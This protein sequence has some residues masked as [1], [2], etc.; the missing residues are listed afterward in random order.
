MKPETLARWKHTRSRGITR[1]ILVT[2]VLSWG[3]PM[4]AVMTFF[5]H[6]AE[7][8]PRLIAMS[9]VIWMLG[10]AAFG[11]IMWYVCERRARQQS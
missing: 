3:V 11:A 2:G 1:Y 4:F 8:S 5:V 10:G 6:H 7:A 9:A